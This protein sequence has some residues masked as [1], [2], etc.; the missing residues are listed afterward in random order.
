MEYMKNISNLI[1]VTEFRL[2]LY[3]RNFDTTRDFYEN[4]LGFK[5]TEEWNNDDLDKG[6]MFDVGGTILELVSGKADEKVYAGYVSLEVPDVLKLWEELK[7]Y[8]KIAQG[9]RNNDWGDTSFSI[10]DP[11]G[12]WI[13]FF[14]KTNIE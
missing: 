11:E 1:K 4:F 12:F 2:K 3:P 5:P 9:L 14:T 8:P 10:Y 7:T 13:T 6:V